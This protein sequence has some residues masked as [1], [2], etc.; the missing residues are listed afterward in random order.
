MIPPIP[1]DLI[2][3]GLFKDFKV[4]IPILDQ[5]AFLLNNFH[6]HF[7][8]VDGVCDG[9]TVEGR[10]A[11]SVAINKLIGQWENPLRAYLIIYPDQFNPLD[12]YSDLRLSQSSKEFHEVLY[13]VA[14]K[15]GFSRQQLSDATARRYSW[16]MESDTS[17][18]VE[19]LAPIYIAMREKGYSHR[20]LTG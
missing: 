15:E 9:E 10:E 18:W 4:Q 1:S 6:M 14:E 8:T 12:C 17:K 16:T 11:V 19:V 13:V 3:F 5:W 7:P 20:D 2:Q